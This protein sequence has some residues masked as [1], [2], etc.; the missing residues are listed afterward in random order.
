MASAGRRGWGSAEFGVL[1]SWGWV[2]MVHDQ[3]PVIVSWEAGVSGVRCKCK[4]VK[5]TQM[6]TQRTLER[7]FWTTPHMLDQFLHELGTRSTTNTNRPDLETTS[8]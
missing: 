5:K 8:S 4:P 1:G 3:R 2:V 6:N 7:R